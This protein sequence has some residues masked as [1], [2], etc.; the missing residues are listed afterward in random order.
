MPNDAKF[1]LL[2]GVTMVIA[3]A[4]VFFRNDPSGGPKPNDP[5]APVV[6]SMALPPVV[7]AGEPPGDGATS[8]PE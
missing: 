5:A 1:G 7:P 8:R 4:V 3:V 2:V 6:K